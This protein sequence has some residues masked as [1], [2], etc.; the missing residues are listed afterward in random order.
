MRGRNGFDSLDIYLTFFITGK[1]LR[2][3]S[4]INQHKPLGGDKV[5]MLPGCVIEW[6]HRTGQDHPASQPELLTTAT[7]FEASSS[8]GLMA[9][10]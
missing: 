8:W 10:T 2:R 7:A 4:S 6:R 1:E 5:F 9:V 3:L